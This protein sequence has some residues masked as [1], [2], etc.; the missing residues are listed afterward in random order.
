MNKQNVQDEINQL[1]QKAKKEGYRLSKYQRYLDICEYRGIELT[2]E[3]KYVL[4]FLQFLDNHRIFDIIREEDDIEAA[5]AYKI[6]KN[7][8]EEG[9]FTL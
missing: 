5:I 3:D 6:V 2:L 4:I 9:R 7:I 8:L 1:E